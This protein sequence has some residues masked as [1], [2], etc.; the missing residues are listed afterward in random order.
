MLRAEIPAELIEEAER[1]AD[2][3]AQT[4]ISSFEERAAHAGVLHQSLVQRGGLAEFADA[5]ATRARAFD[6]AVVPQPEG[7]GLWERELVEA[8]LFGSGRPAL[9]VPYIHRGEAQIERV[10]V[11][12]DGSKE[13]ARAVHDAL[14]LLRRAE[15]VEVLTIHTERRRA[16]AFIP[17]A[18]LA[19]HLVRHGL[20]VSAKGLDGIGIGV[21]EALLSHAADTEVDLVVM[22][23]YAHSRL[24]RLVFGGATSGIL[25]A[26]TSPVL[27]AH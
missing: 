7:D 12:W 2:T 25:S 6:L 13:A 24:R 16:D 4:A 5:F 26:M 20:Q 17:G 19:T 27:M 21:T 22:G 1:Q 9:I 10:L 18:D 3:A 8:V 15:A 23:G 14:P 11:A